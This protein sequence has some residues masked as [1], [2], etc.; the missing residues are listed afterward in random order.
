MTSSDAAI[1]LQYSVGLISSINPNADV[2]NNGQ[3]N[4]IDAQLILQYVAG[5]IHNLPP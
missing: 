4:P 1:V 3:V 2:N 5:L